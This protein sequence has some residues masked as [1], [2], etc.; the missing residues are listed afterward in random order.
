MWDPCT[1]RYT[2]GSCNLFGQYRQL[3]ALFVFCLRVLGEVDLAASEDL[4]GKKD[5]TSSLL[6]R[7]RPHVAHI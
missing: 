7:M 1:G 6:A 3:H 2:S 5:V 4:D